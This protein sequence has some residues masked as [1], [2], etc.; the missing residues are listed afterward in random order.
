M[1]LDDHSQF[2]PLEAAADVVWHEAKAQS[3]G[4]KQRKALDAYIRSL[5]TDPEGNV[6]LDQI[7]GVLRNIH[8]AIKLQDPSYL[9]QKRGFWVPRVPDAIEIAESKEFANQ[10]TSIWQSTKDNLWSIFHDTSLHQPLPY[11]RNKTD[12][13]PPC[14]IVL[15][16]AGGTGKSETTGLSA[17]VTLAWMMMLNNPHVEFDHN[18]ASWIQFVFQGIKQ[19][20]GK[21]TLFDRL[22]YMVD[23]SPWFEK[24]C[25]RNKDKSSELEWPEKRIK[26]VNLSGMFNAALSK[27]VFF[28][29]ITEINEMAVYKNSNKIKDSNKTEF[30][31]GS[32]MWDLLANRTENRFS[33]A[34]GGF[35]GKLIVDSARSH[36]GDFTDQMKRRVKKDARILIVERTLWEA[37]SHLYQKD[38]QRFLVELGDDHRPARIIMTRDKAI[39]PDA[40]V[41]VPE[42]HRHRF[43]D[44][45]EQACCDFL[46]EPKRNTGRFIPFPEKITDAQM[47]YVEVMG[48][49][50]PFRYEEVS[51]LDLFGELKPGEPI[52]WAT[53]INYDYFD[54]ILDK[55]TP[56]ALHVDASTT[57]DATG[58]A[59]GRVIGSKAML[60]A[61]IYSEALGGIQEL[62]NVEAPIYQ[63]DGILCVRAQ[64][65]EIIDINFCEA[66]GLEI[67]RLVNL[68]YASSDWLESW[69]MLLTWRR[70]GIVADKFSVDIKPT[71]YYAYRH[72]LR[73]G[74]LLMQ[75]HT[76]ND[77]ETR[78]LKRI[79]GGNKWKIDHPDGGGSKDCSDAVAAV[80]GVLS[81][82]EGSKYYRETEQDESAF[83]EDDLE[84]YTPQRRSG[85][86]VINSRGGMGKRMLN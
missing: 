17:F 35:P 26:V 52:D 36:D 60:Q 13:N 86:H 64:R 34:D 44:D 12:G 32:N 5:P 79:G 54:A 2:V 40:V 50:R 8:Q 84:A 71:G 68:K 78:Q 67:K 76:V 30:D 25:P 66:L 21:E 65:G 14:I 72:A 23:N 3:I 27:D 49:L 57:G 46:G 7:E 11:T 10:R 43:Q 19:T 83:G 81:L 70:H 48:E 74:R 73:E 15:S 6:R 1:K 39:N 51:F 59:F 16:G 56:F 62:Q 80:L 75:P 28:G 41:E 38:E 77:R 29:A 24:H 37:K 4:I 63:I 85:L 61:H 31:V 53:L 9:A 69:G 18:P 55:Q 42:R 22:Q 47:G 20:T 33:Q 58:I 82:T 45:I